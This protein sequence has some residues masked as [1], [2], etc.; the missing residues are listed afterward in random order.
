MNPLRSTSRARLLAGVAILLVAIAAIGAVALGGSVADNS[1]IV[2]AFDSST[3]TSTSSA[4]TNSGSEGTA[5]EGAAPADEENLMTPSPTPAEP[6]PEPPDDHVED[7]P[8]VN[9]VPDVR[10]FR[11]STEEFDESSHD[12]EDGYITPGEHRL[13]RFDMLTY[14]VGDS[15]AELGHPEDHQD[16]FEH[17]DSHGHSHLKDF[18]DYALFDESGHKV[19]VGK[20][21]A[22]CLMDSQRMLSHSNVSSRPKFDCSYQGISA[23]WA[24]V[25]SASLPGQYLVIDT[26]PDG[27]YTLQATTNAEGMIDENCD[28]DNTVRTGLRINNDTVTE[29][30]T[31]QSHSG[32]TSAC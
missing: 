15:D 21:Q 11:I 22:F 32:R 19:G 24:D 7:R 28:G 10:N 20:K 31:S 25:Y 2:S 12:V 30:H 14:N 27:D 8:G 13:L 1:L 6:D 9:L 26:L 29:I 23:G 18:N 16:Q 5:A 3:D 17:S 4:S